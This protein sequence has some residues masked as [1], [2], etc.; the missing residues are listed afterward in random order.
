M[1]AA[2]RK[3]SA[4]IL[5]I[6]CLGVGSACKDSTGPA[7]NEPEVVE[8]KLSFSNGGSTLIN[9]TGTVQSGPTIEPGRSLS[10]T[11][12]FLDA[13]D[14]NYFSLSPEK[15]ELT[16]TPGPGLTFTRTGPFAGTLTAGSSTGTVPV[17]FGLLHITKNHTDFGPFTLNFRVGFLGGQ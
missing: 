4:L 6:I 16:V 1:F 17:Q 10:F 11:A 3:S 13:A 15:F 5:S 12:Q 8:I 14:T 9:S 2:A 7:D